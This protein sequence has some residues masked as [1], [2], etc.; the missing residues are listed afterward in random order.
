MLKRS[1]LEPSFFGW[2][3]ITSNSW[4]EASVLDVGNQWDGVES[5]LN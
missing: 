2:A 5:M 1:H 4:S 3:V